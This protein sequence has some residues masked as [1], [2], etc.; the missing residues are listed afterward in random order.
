VRRIPQKKQGYSVRLREIC[1]RVSIPPGVP[2]MRYP[3]GPL[4]LDNYRVGS[5]LARVLSRAMD[6]TPGGGQFTPEKSGREPGR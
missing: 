3:K 2:E 1:F 5:R 6:R 4:N